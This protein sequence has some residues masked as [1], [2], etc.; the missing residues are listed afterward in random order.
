MAFESASTRSLMIL[1]GVIAAGA[2]IFMATAV[3]PA[4]NLIRGTVTEEATVV[5]SSGG[6]CIVDTKDT[7][8]SAKTISGCDMSVGSKVKVSYQ[9]GLA[10]AQ[11]VS[12]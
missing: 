5:E 7:A 12:P 9:K 6:K 11:I 1:F 2:I 3:F 10:S 8:L 4:T